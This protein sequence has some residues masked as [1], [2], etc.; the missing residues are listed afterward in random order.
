MYLT[1]KER[2]RRYLAA[3]PPSVSGH[4]G[5]HQLYQAAFYLIVGFALD[6]Q[7]AY[8]LLADYNERAKP[9]WPESRLHYKLNQALQ[10]AVDN[11]DEIGFL[12]GISRW[13]EIEIMERQAVLALNRQTSVPVVGKRQR[14]QQSSGIAGKKALADVYDAVD[15]IF[16]TG[17]IR[18]SQ[19]QRSSPTPV[20]WPE[21][22]DWRWWL[23][24]WH[25]DDVIWV[26]DK[27]DSGDPKKSVHFAS[28]TEWEELSRTPHKYIADFSWTPPDFGEQTCGSSFRPGS[29]SR[30][31]TNVLHRRFLVTEIDSL[32]GRPVPKRIQ[33]GI[34]D[35]INRQ[36]GFRL[37]AVCDSGGKSLHAFWD[38]PGEHRERWLRRIGPALGL[39][40][41]LFVPCQPCR[42]PGGIRQNRGNEC[43]RL[44]YLD[45]DQRHQQ[46]GISR[47][48]N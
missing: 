12:L 19:L 40:D 42:L 48:S 18:L 41:Q 22:D 27:Y 13:A 36:P 1:S 31:N 23:K 37:R 4:G 45:L 14:I 16:A 24:L 21:E 46:V 8:S 47:S 38:Y 34:I 10:Y 35:W 3:V 29:Y 26:G 2:A 5:D 30:S 15:D 25:P 9:P 32:Y 44:Y 33:A 17:G 28:R 20:T 39:D 6:L 7:D 11:T 43:Q